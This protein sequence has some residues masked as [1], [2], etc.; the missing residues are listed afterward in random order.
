[1]AEDIP[2]EVEVEMPDENNVIYTLL[3][4]C[5]SLPKA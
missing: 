5:R 3:Y 1:M 4:I 2:V